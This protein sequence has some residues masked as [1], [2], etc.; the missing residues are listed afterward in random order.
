MSV[1]A[2]TYDFLQLSPF[3]LKRPFRP[4]AGR[5]TD[6]WLARCDTSSPPS[7]A[8]SRRG[9]GIFGGA[10]PGSRQSFPP[11]A[12]RQLPR[13]KAGG[14][15]PAR[16]PAITLSGRAHAKQPRSSHPGQHPVKRRGMRGSVRLISSS[17]SASIVLNT[18]ACSGSPARLFIS[19]GSFVRSKSSSS[20]V[21]LYMH[22]L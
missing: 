10:S 13:R 3:V 6:W 14:G 2:Q 8:A 22:S 11:Q 21:G 19:C 12:G 17:I 18:T 1:D 15:S 4:C 7:P 16:F 9:G 20:R 5:A